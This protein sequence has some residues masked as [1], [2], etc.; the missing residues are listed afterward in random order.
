MIIR[1]LKA[2]PFLAVVGVTV[3]ASSGA[4]ARIVPPTEGYYPPG[5][6]ITGPGDCCYTDSSM[7][8]KICYPDQ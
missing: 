5:C 3:I 2:F 1:I 6:Q 7:T 4:Q 8:V